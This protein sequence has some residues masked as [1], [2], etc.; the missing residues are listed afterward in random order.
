MFLS[1]TWSCVRIM[2]LLLP[3]L[4]E[5]ALTVRPARWRG[6]VDSCKA[7]T[8]P[9]QLS[10]TRFPP[11]SLAP[12]ELSASLR[13]PLAA[14]VSASSCAHNRSRIRDRSWTIQTPGDCLTREKEGLAGEI[15]GL[16]LLRRRSVSNCR[17]NRSK[18]W[19]TISTK[20]P[21]IRTGR[22]SCWSLRSADCRRRRQRW[23]FFMTI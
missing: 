7:S 17:R 11:R 22:R 9:P 19:R 2:H 3:C 12:A 4:G 6:S 1:L 13:P 23:A 8:H 5:E 18:C 16:W 21:S 14:R 20:S 15:T 10:H